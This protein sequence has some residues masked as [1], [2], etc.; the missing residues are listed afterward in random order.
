MLDSKVRV[1][2]YRKTI[3][4]QKREMHAKLHVQTVQLRVRDVNKW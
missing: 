4:V 1:F 3:L 2:L